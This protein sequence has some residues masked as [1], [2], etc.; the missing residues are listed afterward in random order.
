MLVLLIQFGS[1]VSSDPGLSIFEKLRL[2][3]MK[4]KKFN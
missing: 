1:F 4:G 2:L 3:T